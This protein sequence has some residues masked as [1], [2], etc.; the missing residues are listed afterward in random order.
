LN[1]SYLDDDEEKQPWEEDEVFSDFEYWIKV[2]L[3][4]GEVSLL[5]L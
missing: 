2:Y 5:Y 3:S 1:N 4:F